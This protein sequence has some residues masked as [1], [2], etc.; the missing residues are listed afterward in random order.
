MANL[1]TQ[2]VGT[3]G[4]NW[5]SATTVLPLKTSSGHTSDIAPGTWLVDSTGWIGIASNATAAS[6][7]VVAI[8]DSSMRAVKDQYLTAAQANA[9][10][11]YVDAFP[12]GGCEFEMIEDGTGGGMN[13]TTY[14]S[15]AD[16]VVGTSITF[17][18]NALVGTATVNYKVDSSTLSTSSSNLFLQILAP[19]GGPD[20]PAYDGTTARRW[21]VKVIDSL[22]GASL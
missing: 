4:R 5:R 7:V 11:Y 15:Y 20:N 17:G 10:Q 9:A 3:G 12:V 19:G 6:Y 18:A 14:P 13:V 16:I 2:L 8:Y 21:R 22:A 1:V